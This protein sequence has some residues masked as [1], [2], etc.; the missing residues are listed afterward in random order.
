MSSVSPNVQTQVQIEVLKKA[1]EMQAQQTRQLVEAQVQQ[2]K[3][4]Q[5]AP[6]PEPGKAGS[7]IN[8]YA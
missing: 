3:E 4:A 1:N 6:P 5:A 2:Q 8:T 7:V